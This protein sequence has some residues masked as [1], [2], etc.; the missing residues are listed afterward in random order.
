V[1][2]VVQEGQGE[3]EDH[4]QQE[5]QQIQLMARQEVQEEGVRYSILEEILP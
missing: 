2:S 4:V 1:L 5:G 3:E